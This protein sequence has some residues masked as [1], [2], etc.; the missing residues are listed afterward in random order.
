MGQEIKH[1]HFSL[2]DEKNFLQKFKQENDLLRTWFLQ[3]KFK[4]SEHTLGLEL[5]AWLVTKDFIP[6]PVSD[7]F[8]DKV[9]H[10]FV[11]PEI[12]KF[13]FELNTD[14]FVIAPLVFSKMEHELLTLWKACE[15]HADEMGYMAV[16]IGTLP[17]LRDHMLTLDCLTPKKRYF[18]LNEQLMKMRDQQPIE[19]HLSGKD[20][21]HLSHKDVMTECAATSMQVHY[22]I[23]LEDSVKY[24]NAAII[25]SAFMAAVG[26]N[27]PFLMGKE[28]GD[29]TRISVFEQSVNFKTNYKKNVPDRVGLGSGYVQNSLME[30]FDENFDQY[31]VLLPDVQN[32][33][34]IHRLEHLRLQNGTIWRWNRPLIGF[35]PDGSPSL[36]L[37]LRVP[38]AGPTIKD[39][40]ANMVFQVALLEVL[41]KIKDIEKLIPFETAKKNFYEA[42]Q[43]GLDA[44]IFWTDSR[45]ENIQD[46]IFNKL[47]PE[48]AKE[49]HNLG[50]HDSDINTYLGDV[51]KP[52]IKSGQNGANWQKAFVHTHGVRFQEMLQK[53]YS[54]QVKNIPVHL[55][56]V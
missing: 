4:N 45:K 15:K 27:S 33:V 29:E 3:K 6:A 16:M 24:Y 13:N 19:I 46:I 43:F 30:L 42:C 32:N 23:K 38:S 39:V 55:W 14:P 9:K 31:P 53:Y 41:V 22:S 49:L 25:S 44:K 37:E 50:I 34:Q 5:E 47:L 10:P 26:A 56:E 51:I 35:F 21:I 52:R 28:L 7:Q 2:E 18:A 40:V 48:C 17:T 54:Y 36:R 20:E 11:V 1:T 8:V 12:S